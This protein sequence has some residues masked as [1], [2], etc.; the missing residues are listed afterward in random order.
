M[1]SI[2]FS[3]WDLDDQILSAI[4]NK[5]WEFTTQI[6]AEAIPLARRG[7][8]VVGQARTGSGKTAAFGIPCIENTE[9]RGVPQAIIISPTRELAHQI[10][11]E[12]QWLQGDKGLGIITVYGGTDIDKQAKKLDDGV[13]IIVGTPGRI[14]DMT[15]RGHLKLENMTT[16]CLDEADRMLDMGFFPDII[17]VL[18]KMENRQQTMLFSATF[19]D[20]VIE[21][22]NTFLTDAEHVM[23]DDLEVEIPAI[24]Q[25]AISVGR[26]NKLWAL[27]R[28]LVTLSDE[29]QM[30]IFTNTKRMVD[31]LVQRL[32]KFRFNAAGLHGDM[33][34]G[35]RGRIIESFKNGHEKVLICTDVAARGIDVDGVTVVVNYDLPDDVE[36][37]VHRIGR[38]GR[39]GREGTAWSFVSNDDEGQ[40]A[41]IA[42]TW[43]L[44]IPFCD[45][46]KL[47]EGVDRDPVRRQQDWGE[48]AN[49]FG[50]VPVSV[51]IGKND[52]VN[53]H[54]LSNWF[55]GGA[56]LNEL[57][58][59]EVDIRDN[60]SIVEIHLDK[61]EGAIKVMS[62]KD[63]DGRQVSIIIQK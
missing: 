19:P 56:K 35:K 42:T 52:G 3:D 12:M 40:L 51:S 15:K 62:N 10:A 18:E 22:A 47:P 43:D 5:G 41:K 6:Q 23:S 39:M 44:V 54:T 28:I 38:T 26:A 36:S 58:I 16:L 8:N 9:A 14:I 55:S 45:A 32:S 4:S 30:M 34:Q 49:N 37:Y 13:D 59:G 17:W 46:P 29:E 25:K 21:A 31:I 33:P 61:V 27:G 24:E 1:S 2:R 20:E 7:K 53:N 11:E 60:E 63:W 57:A 50:M 48:V